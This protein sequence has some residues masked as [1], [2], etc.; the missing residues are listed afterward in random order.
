ML[1]AMIAP[2]LPY[3]LGAAA[4]AA[5]ALGYGLYARGRSSGKADQRAAQDRS[6]RESLERQNEAAAVAPRDRGA[7]GKRLRDGTF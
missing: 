1:S 2:F 5:V 3:I 6:N 4:L 7:L